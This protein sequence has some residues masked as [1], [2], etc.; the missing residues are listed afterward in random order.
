MGYI[1]ECINT[2]GY[3]PVF[4]VLETSVQ[5]SVCSGPERPADETTGRVRGTFHVPMCIVRKLET[6]PK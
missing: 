1:L 6:F 5:E 4:P 2:Q 3:T